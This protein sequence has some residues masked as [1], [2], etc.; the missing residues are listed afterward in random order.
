MKTSGMFLI[1]G[2]FSH[3]RRAEE[4][5]IVYLRG[6]CDRFSLTDQA[7]FSIGVVLVL[8]KFPNLFDGVD[9][10]LECTISGI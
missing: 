4:R 3:W 9:N 5:K 6:V 8:P 10:C 2:L 7:P 1:F